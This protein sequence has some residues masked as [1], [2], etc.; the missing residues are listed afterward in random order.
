MLIETF[1]TAAHDVFVPDAIVRAELGISQMTQWRWDRD[2]ALA[3]LGW[4]PPVRAPG[5][6]TKHRSRRQLEQFKANML[7]EAFAA[8]G[9]K[10][11][12]RI[13]A[14]PNRLL[15]GSDTESATA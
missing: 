6:R 15:K 13:A 3:A 14:L 2:P 12:A 5:G 10:S 7:Q 4:P 8:R 1:D 11:G 9:K